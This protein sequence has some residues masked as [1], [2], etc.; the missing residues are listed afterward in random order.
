M[1]GWLHQVLRGTKHSLWHTEAP[2]SE[3][4]SI[5]FPP[6]PHAITRNIPSTGLWPHNYGLFFAPHHTCEHRTEVGAAG[7]QDHTV[8]FY[9][10]IFRHNHH[11][12]Q[13]LFTVKHQWGDS[14]G[15]STNAHPQPYKD[16]SC[17]HPDS[18]LPAHKA[19]RDIRR[20]ELGRGMNS[21]TFPSP[22]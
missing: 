14:M 13:Q 9:F 1:L 19:V 6:S 11:V 21:S 2:H 20:T 5:L 10:D 22:C 18:M 16:I 15:H 7:C 8:G 17:F 3:R 4:H 12:T